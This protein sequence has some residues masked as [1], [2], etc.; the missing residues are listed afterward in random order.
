MISCQPYRACSRSLLMPRLPLPL[1]F[2]FLLLAGCASAGPAS[3]NDP[4]ADVADLK[5]DPGD[6]ASRVFAGTIYGFQPTTS[7][8]KIATN[9]TV[10]PNPVHCRYTA[11]TRFFLD[12]QPAT[13]DQI[14][15]YM[16]VRVKGRVT[17]DAFII[18]TARFSSRL[19][20]NVRPAPTP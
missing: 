5:P 16:P 13:L 6:P 18:E 17:P 4:A 14:Q 1:L 12:G 20:A 2:T 9:D 8:M 19:P 3:T 15:Q 7:T 11:Q 10:P